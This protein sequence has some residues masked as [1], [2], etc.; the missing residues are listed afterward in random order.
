VQFQPQWA[1]AGVGEQL[2]IAT[3]RREA[4]DAAVLE[5]GVD[6]AVRVDGDILGAGAA[7]G[8]QIGA[9]QTIIAL[10]VAVQT[11]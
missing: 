11:R 8:E 6:A 1:A 10:V 9:C 3:S 4:Q 2:G 5:T 7:H